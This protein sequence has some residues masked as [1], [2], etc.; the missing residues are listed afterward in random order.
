[1]TV[2]KEG[3]LDISGLEINQSYLRAI[4]LGRNR[5]YLKIEKIAEIPLNP[6][7][8]ENGHLQ[9]TEQ[10]AK[11]LSLFLK[12]NHFS[13]SNWIVSIAD[14][15]VFTTYKMFPSLSSES[16]AEAVEINSA[17]VLPGKQEN[18]YWGWQEIEPSG[19]TAG[20][21]VVISSIL[22]A[23]LNQ[24]ISA[25]SKIGIV[26]IAI[27]PKSL[28]I[29]RVFG[30]TENTLVINFEGTILN[31]TIIKNGFTRFTR[32]AKIEAKP[33]EQFKGLIAEIKKV[34]NFYLIEKNE[35]KITKIVLDGSGARAE[36]KTPLKEV[37]NIP[38][39][40][41]SEIFQIGS[42]KV[43][44][45]PLVGVGLRA[46]VNL[47]DDNSLS[48]LPVGT[49][50]ATEEKRALLFYGGLANIIVITCLLLM[51]LFVGAFGLQTYLN[52][53][54]TAQ[55]AI[56]SK[57]Q[58]SSTSDSGDLQKE[59]SEIKPYLDKEL[60][61]ENQIVPI[62]PAISQL[63]ESVPSGI[64]ITQLIFQSGTTINLSGVAQ[65]RDA[66]VSYRDKL[67]GLDIVSSVQM[68]TSNFS[69][70]NNINFT[71]VITLK[72]AN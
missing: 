21:E 7:I 51:A 54:I 37:F 69:N 25:F 33:E 6:G 18:I 72:K 17:S 4:K 47:K 68:P 24:Y 50:E 59:I 60:N 67:S 16:L 66:L 71:I 23:Q 5:G 28:S 27:E 13:S 10:F 38:V 56:V 65:S 55:L 19:K 40:L 12:K 41:S 57:S 42:F 11:I 26:P 15:A 49:K 48:L 44:S 39:E 8:V 52:Q 29:A 62:S 32:E 35:E 22:K 2:G 36:F 61:I 3:Q 9:D 53:K 30:K 14:D 31:F 20:K 43:F 1:M 46:L 63:R 58:G 70:A 45:L 64:T 34:T